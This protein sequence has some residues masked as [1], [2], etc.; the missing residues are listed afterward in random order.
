M[1]NSFKKVSALIACLFAISCQ[2]STATATD[3]RPIYLSDI[4]PSS[5]LEPH[6]E[7]K[8]MLDQLG[9]GAVY[10][11]TC[12]IQYNNNIYHEVVLIFGS[13]RLMLYPIF[14]VNDVIGNPVSLNQPSNKYVA[15]Q[16]Q[17]S[18]RGHYL[19]IFNNHDSAY[20]SISG[21]YARLATD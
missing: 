14:S 15:Q 2:A 17:F 7:A 5:R 12:N 11:V 13:S 16:V 6:Q 10:T 4:Q 9:W 3:T 1:K 20:I 19:S 21:C 18:G 8:I